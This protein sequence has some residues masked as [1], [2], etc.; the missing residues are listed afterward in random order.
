M[1]EFRK[2]TV[3]SSQWRRKRTL[4]C[5]CRGNKNEPGES[6]PAADSLRYVVGSAEQR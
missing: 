4:K 5:V 6:I 3:R 1:N 2:Y